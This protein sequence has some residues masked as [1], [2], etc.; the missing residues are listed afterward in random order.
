MKFFDVATE[1]S[2][3]ALPIHE[4]AEHAFDDVALFVDGAVVALLELAVAARRDDGLCAAV[5]EP[6]A[7]VLAVVALVGDELSGRWQGPDAGLGDLA[8]VDVA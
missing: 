3:E 1:A 7:Q 5:V 8:V 6:L 4:A 2:S